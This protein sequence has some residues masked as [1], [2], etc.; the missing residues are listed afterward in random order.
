MCN[1]QRPIKSLQKIMM[2]FASCIMDESKEYKSNKIVESM[3]TSK[4]PDH[5][6]GGYSHQ[7]RWSPI[8]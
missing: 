5:S 7:E 1:G 3:I 4:E 2:S 8:R 6:L